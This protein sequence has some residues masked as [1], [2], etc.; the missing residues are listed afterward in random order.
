MFDIA[1]AKFRQEMKL[2][3]EH[4]AGGICQVFPGYP[5]VHFNM[6]LGLGFTEPVTV[7][8]LQQV[9]TIYKKAEQSVYLIQFAEGIQ[10][11]E[12]AN[13]FEL[14]NYRVG[15]IWE[16]IV[17]HAASVTALS[18]NRDIYV[19]LVDHSTV[20]AWEKFIL[21]LYHYPAEGWLTAFVT[22]KWYNFIA[23]E[24]NNIIACR[25]VFIDDGIAWSGVEAPVPIVMTN[26]LEPDRIIW[27]HIQQLCLEKNVKLIAADIEMPA[28]GRDTAIYKS[29]AELGFTVA[30]SRKLY[31]KNS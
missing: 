8:V 9:E 25:S 5:V 12:P 23:I 2:H 10:Q 17:W 15:G 28:P 30:Y 20:N 27:T 4:V 1:P 7:E 26:D 22:D 18:S 29:F 21:D 6:V 19:E 14:M 3:Y 13:V 24:N 16:R 11:A 31:R